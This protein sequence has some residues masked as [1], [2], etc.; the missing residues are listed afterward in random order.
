MSVIM[1][2]HVS[3]LITARA[4]T[5][6]GGMIATPPSVVIFK[7]M[8]PCLPVPMAAYA[9]TVMT[10]IVSRPSPSSPV[11]IPTWK[12][13]IRG[14]V[15]LIVACLCVFRGT[16]I[17]TVRTYHRHPGEKGVIDVLMVAIVPLLISVNVR[18]DGRAMI[19]VHRPVRP[20]LMALLGS[21]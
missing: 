4:R 5:G 10:A 1:V 2:G 17:L 19:A 8:A 14:G 21:S 3:H 6:G 11:F 18:M 7:P 16:S 15:G 13:A 9:S 12:K 20:W